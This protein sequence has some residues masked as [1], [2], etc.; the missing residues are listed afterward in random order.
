MV[1]DGEGIRLGKEKGK[2]KQK[3]KGT[4]WGRGRG[5]SSIVPSI[6]SQF[7]KSESG[8][9]KILIR[10]SNPFGFGV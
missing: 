4:S 8:G 9:I 7:N 6:F 1:G 10:K 5:A 3:G 2:G